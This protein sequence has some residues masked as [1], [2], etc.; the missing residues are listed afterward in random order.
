MHF[1]SKMHLW[2][3]TAKGP[4][5]LSG[6]LGRQWA[7]FFFFSACPNS[8]LSKQCMQKSTHICKGM[9]MPWECPLV[10]ADELCRGLPQNYVHNCS[11]MSLG[12][13]GGLSLWKV[14]PLH[15]A[16]MH[17]V[18]KKCNSPPLCAWPAF[19][20]SFCCCRN[21][22]ISAAISSLLAPASLSCCLRDL[23]F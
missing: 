20:S 12:C 15:V 4:T 14:P 10:Q 3:L 9:H 21:F 2:L 7:T 19:H 11:S 13:C 22:S 23:L 16:C 8:L 1:K 18:S 17:A 5:P 6:L